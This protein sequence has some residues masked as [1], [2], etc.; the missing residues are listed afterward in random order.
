MKEILSLSLR[1]REI[2][3]LLLFK[4]G[5]I[6]VKSL[7]SKYQLSSKSIQ[8]DLKVITRQLALQNISLHT[9]AGSVQIIIS[10]QQREQLLRE[11]EHSDVQRDF[12]EKDE[13]VQY[14]INY[15]L[16]STS[17]VTS[18]TL[19]EALRVSKPTILSDL[20]TVQTLLK[21][22]HFT[23][24]RQK[25]KGNWIS[26]EES[27][28]RELIV[29]QLTILL[30]SRRINDHTQLFRLCEKGSTNPNDL[31]LRYLSETDSRP[32][33]EAIQYLL[34]SDRVEINGEN[35]F[36]LA[37]LLL[38]TIRRLTEGN[39]ISTPVLSSEDSDR[40]DQMLALAGKLL[41]F[42]GKYHCI[43]YNLYESQFL[44]YQ[45]YHRSIRL[46][47]HEDDVTSEWGH[48]IG[49]MMDYINTHSV[50]Y[51]P[52]TTASYDQ[53][54]RRELTDYLELTSRRKRL[55]IHAYNPLCVQ[56]KAAYPKLYFIAERLS[57]IAEEKANLELTQDDLGTLTLI[58]AAYGN[59]DSVTKRA[60]LVCDKG[61]MIT[62]A[63]SRRLQNNISG[64]VISHI[65]SVQKFMEDPTICSNFDLVITTTA[66]PDTSLPT[67]LVSPIIDYADLQHIQDMVNGTQTPGLNKTLPWGHHQIDSYVSRLLGT[68]ITPAEVHAISNHFSHLLTECTSQATA[69]D[70]SA[71]KE[72]Y[73]RQM[74]T[75]FSRL[76]PLIQRSRDII[77][78]P[79]ALDNLLGLVI[80][81]C[82]NL[83]L[84]ENGGIHFQNDPTILQQE[85]PLL[86][87]AV[88]DFLFD[89]GKLIG[90]PLPQSEAIP[91]LQYF[92][93]RL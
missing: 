41:S 2:L 49:K 88:K 36:S 1:Q 8:N 89:I 11:L 81:L 19:C 79:P 43:S 20:E 40:E 57:A 56:A 34:E 22:K 92:K 80:H 31:L 17:P 69:A 5:P 38:V 46:S 68:V 90:T 15:L 9:E 63:L 6:S 77:G 67:F 29:K 10:P 66:L 48:I 32:V 33:S 39:Q 23:L 7:I 60:L 85:N 55:G 25:G 3:S 76:E 86:V 45:L 14:I 52:D 13:R 78:S 74:A 62:N 35:A 50:P 28:L 61:S 83:V 42:A 87:E 37:I 18:T 27:R 21:Q 54:L 30:S 73:S 58:L 59:F 72:R 4:H 16:F 26:G 47:P 82:L 51:Q 64:L 75:I 71:V 65:S 12:W 44:V 84:W 53:K 91:I 24:V 93:D 70:L